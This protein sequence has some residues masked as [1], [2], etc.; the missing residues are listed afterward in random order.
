[1]YELYF[2]RD[3]NGREPLREYIEELSKREDKT[4]RINLAKINDYLQMLSVYGTRAGEPYIKHI[5][6][7]LWELR[8][9]RNR[10]FFVVWYNNSFVILNYFIKKTQKTP[11]RE[12]EKAK[13]LIKN[14]E[15]RGL[16]YGK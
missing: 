12:I 9:L 13:R 16:D 10:I 7:N 15:E 8:P 1:M 3:E 6:G 2:Y 11:R 14:I 5:E 4:S